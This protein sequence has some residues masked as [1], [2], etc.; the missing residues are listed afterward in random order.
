MVYP[1]FGVVFAKGING[2]SLST[3]A[4]RRHAGDRTALW[5]FLIAII[6]TTTITFQNRLFSLAAANLTARLRSL[7]F[8]SMLR[9]DSKYT[10]SNLF[11]TFY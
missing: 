4:E 7:S 5:L 6:S 10:I 2:F 9:Q 1:A 3:N 11:R 8:K